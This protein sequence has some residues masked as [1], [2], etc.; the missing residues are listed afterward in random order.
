MSR[1]LRIFEQDKHTQRDKLNDFLAASFFESRQNVKRKDTEKGKVR[2]RTLCSLPV[3]QAA[4]S[5][6]KFHISCEGFNRPVFQ[7][8]LTSMSAEVIRR[9]QQLRL[10]TLLVIT[11]TRNM[12][13]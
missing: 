6:K 4:L 1:V 13:M 10:S 12:T 3:N 9:S 8:C 5:Q 2:R 11:E 7:L